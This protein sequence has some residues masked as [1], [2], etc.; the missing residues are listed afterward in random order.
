MTRE[1]S[2]KLPQ[3]CR[4]LFEMRNFYPYEVLNVLSILSILQKDWNENDDVWIMCVN[5]WAVK[6]SYAIEI[7]YRRRN[8]KKV[9]K[10][11][12]KI[13]WNICICLKENRNSMNKKKVICTETK[14]PVDENWQKL[15]FKIL[16]NNLFRIKQKT[17]IW[18]TRRFNTATN[19]SSG[20]FLSTVKVDFPIHST[21]FLWQKG[22]SGDFNRRI[23]QTIRIAFI[24]CM[25]ICNEYLT[26]SR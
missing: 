25:N 3:V 21:L 11:Y 13:C 1:R 7:S 23:Q 24:L 9:N 12:K 8:G 6:K 18:S 19:C 22:E 14:S 20:S 5:L 16:A 10:R 17:F 26:T 15:S 4:L 2:K